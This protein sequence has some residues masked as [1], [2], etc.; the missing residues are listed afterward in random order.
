MSQTVTA[1]FEDGVLKPT[2]PLRIGEGTS[3]RI[4][5]DAVEPTTDQAARAAEMSGEGLRQALRRLQ[6][7]G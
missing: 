5:I 7:R 1:I 2:E 4:T 6:I 3:V